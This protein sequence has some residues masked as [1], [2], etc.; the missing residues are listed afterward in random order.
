MHESDRGGF[1][2]MECFTPQ[3]CMIQ[4]HKVLDTLGQCFTFIF[5]HSLLKFKNMNSQGNMQ[6]Q[7]QASFGITGEKMRN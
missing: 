1:R 5:S 6:K 3:L 2:T 7:N 4:G